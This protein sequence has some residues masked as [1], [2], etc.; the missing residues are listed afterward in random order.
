MSNTTVKVPQGGGSITITTA[1]ETRKTY[2]VTGT[3]KDTGTISVA[4]DQLAHVLR[5][6][7]GAEL[8]KGEEPPADATTD[9]TQPPELPAP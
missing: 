6:V 9:V 3:G 1:G 4:D 5:V 8:P 7:P 2:K